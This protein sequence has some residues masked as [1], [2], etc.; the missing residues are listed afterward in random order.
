MSFSPTVEAPVP[1]T[2][3][4][5][6]PGPGADPAAGEAQVSP[7]TT[8]FAPIHT[9]DGSVYNTE[10]DALAALRHKAERV[11]EL[12][13]RVRD[14]ETRQSQPAQ[15]PVNPNA[16]QAE[17]VAE[18]IKFHIDTGFS[19]AAAQR[20]AQRDWDIQQRAEQRAV[21]KVQGQLQQDRAIRMNQSLQR[22]GQID[23]RFAN[24]GAL[25]TP[26]QK[27]YVRFL[28]TQNPMSLPEDHVAEFQQVFGA[29]Q[30]YGNGHAANGQNGNGVRF[31][32]TTN[33]SNGPGYGNGASQQDPPEVLAAINA[34]KARLSRSGKLWVDSEAQAIRDEYYGAIK[35]MSPSYDGAV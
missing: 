14:L 19:E 20:M 13:A 24:E 21:G 11:A 23:P 29:P 4:M 1:V 3:A 31:P 30:G 18:A 8:A 6:A 27:N 22:A 5:D 26:Q 28:A 25:M 12:N 9:A 34:H 10:A 32:N 7:Q 15:P 16:E 33:G 17:F 2:P 35:R